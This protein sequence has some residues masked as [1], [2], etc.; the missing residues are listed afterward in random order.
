MDRAPRL[1]ATLLFVLA[2][3]LAWNGCAKSLISLAPFPCAMDGT[4][5][6][7]FT[8]VTQQG[9]TAC[10]PSLSCPGGQSQCGDACADV[11]SDAANCGGCGQACAPGNTCC[12]GACADLT[13]DAAHC[14]SC[15]NACQNAKSCL[16]GTCA[17]TPEQTTCAGDCADLKTDMNNCGTCGHA[18]SN[19]YC[20]SGACHACKPYEQACPGGC[21]SNTD[22]NNCG[23]CGNSC[24]GQP[25]TGGVCGSNTCNG[26]SYTCATAGDVWYCGST[27]GG[28]CKAQYPYFC[29]NAAAP[30]WNSPIDCSTIVD[31]GGAYYGCSTGEHYDCGAMTCVSG[32]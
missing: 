9:G 7:G 17:C 10:Y 13:S 30:C 21:V 28:C 24:N 23:S 14:G 26:M 18:C 22:P 12:Q 6:D 2:S 5:P 15:D 3:T 1:A 31:C 16:S 25:C 20:F 8:C 4:C 11:S 27:T 19:A 29:D 32:G